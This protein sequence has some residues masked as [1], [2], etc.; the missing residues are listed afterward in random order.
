MRPEPSIST[1]RFESITETLQELFSTFFPGKRFLGPVPTED[2]NLGFPVAMTDGTKHDINDL[3][4]GE[5]E[6]LFGYLRIRHSAPGYSI[7]LMDEPEL[8]LNP[9]LIRGLPQFYYKHLSAEL[10]NQVWLVTHSDALLR[11]AIGHRGLRVFHMRHAMVSKSHENQIREIEP[12][13]EVESILLEMVGNLATYS[14]GAKIVF[15]EGESSDFDL[16]MVSRLFPTLENELNLV[17]GGNRLR[18]ERIHRIL[19]ECVQA[20]NIPIKIYS[21]VDKDSGPVIDSPKEFQRHFTWDVYHIEN[22][23]LEPLYIDEVL[24]RLDIAH[25]ELSSLGRIDQCLRQIAKG[26]INRLAVHKLNSVVNTKLLEGLKLRPN[27]TAADIGAEYHSSIDTALI[28]MK[29]RLDDDLKVE[30]LQQLV[31]AEQVRLTRSSKT[32]NWKKHFRGR[33]IL[34]AF[35]GKYVPGMRYEYFRDLILSQMSSASYQPAGMRSV[36]ERIHDD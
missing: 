26:Q 28:R 24:G 8:H 6:I 19:E 17:S 36:L 20:G 11:E 31:D 32:E 22:Y 29:S 16:R 23:L 25:S 14:P 5:K 3:S 10:N 12:G 33:D 27:P 7:V 2:G 4:S 13:A 18:V 34:R 21:V 35:A 30:R 9:A 15:F 1:S